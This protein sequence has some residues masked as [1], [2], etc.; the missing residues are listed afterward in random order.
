MA[1]TTPE[2]PQTDNNTNET[3]TPNWKK[4]VAGATL[5]VMGIAGTAAG[6]GVLRS[7]GS[8]DAPRQNQHSVT[9]DDQ[10]A[11][12]I[13][14]RLEDLNNDGVIDDTQYVNGKLTHKGVEK[15]EELPVNNTLTPEQVQWIVDI[16]GIKSLHPNAYNIIRNFEQERALGLYITI[17]NQVEDGTFSTG[18][19][20]ADVLDF[21]DPNWKQI[22]GLD[23]NSDNYLGQTDSDQSSPDNST[24]QLTPGQSN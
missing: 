3:N 21:M 23:P 4:R 18:D 17:K 1:T 22:N 5:A 16:S 11:N 19:Y 2:A 8:P 6:F 24:S 10:N 12:G 14:D 20:G 9:A 7:G 13:P 15:I